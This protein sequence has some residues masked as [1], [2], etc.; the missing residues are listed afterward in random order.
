MASSRHLPHAAAHRW[1]FTRPRVHRHVLIWSLIPFLLI[2]IAVASA[3]AYARTKVPGA[4][5]K[6]SSAVVEPRSSL[7]QPADRFI[8][9]VIAEDGKLGWHQLCPDIQAQLPIDTL[10]QQADTMR[11]AAKKEGAW[12]TAKSLGTHSQNGGWL[13]HD[14]RMTAHWPTGATRQWTYAILTQPSGCVEDIQSQDI[15]AQ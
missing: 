3:A 14:Y 2:S 11:A 15:Q 5:S 9:S 8:Q 7:S 12:L 10:V 4:V 13:I 6:A 1:R